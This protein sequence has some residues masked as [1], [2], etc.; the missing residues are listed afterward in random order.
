MEKVTVV[1]GD[2]KTRIKTSMNRSQKNQRHLMK[3]R[4]HEQRGEGRT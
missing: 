3:P 1:Q 2:E 4:Q